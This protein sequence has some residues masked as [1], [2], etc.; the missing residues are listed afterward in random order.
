LR[1]IDATEIDISRDSIRQSS[2]PRDINNLANNRDSIEYTARLINKEE[3]I[4][5]KLGKPLSHGS[6]DTP[7]R[8]S[9]VLLIFVNTR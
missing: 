2:A 4:S 3:R 8:W 1:A 5:E 7:A 9:G 6:T